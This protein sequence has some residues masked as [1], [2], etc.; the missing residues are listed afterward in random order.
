MQLRIYNQNKDRYKLQI[1]ALK[2]VGRL[3]WCTSPEH[4]YH[5]FKIYKMDDLYKFELSKFIRGF[6]KSSSK[7]F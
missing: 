1:K 6:L 7:I 4:L 2:A 3:N 5:R